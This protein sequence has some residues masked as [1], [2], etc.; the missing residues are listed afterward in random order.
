M[1]DRD[2]PERRPPRAFTGKNARLRPQ[3]KGA[4]LSGGTPS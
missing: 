4:G 1:K 2:L 3:S